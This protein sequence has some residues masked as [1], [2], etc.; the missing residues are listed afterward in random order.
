[1]NILCCGSWI[2]SWS[3]CCGMVAQC[4]L[5]LENDLFPFSYPPQVFRPG[6]IQQSSASSF[7][8][9]SKT[10][11]GEWGSSSHTSIV[12]YSART[13]PLILWLCVSKV[14]MTTRVRKDRKKSFVPRLGR[15]NKKEEDECSPMMM[16][17]HSALRSTRI[18][19]TI[20]PPSPPPPTPN[21]PHH[22]H[23]IL[24]SQIFQILHNEKSLEIPVHF[25]PMTKRKVHPPLGSTRV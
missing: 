16:T 15:M 22:H 23:P 5:P 10:L 13:T 1:M 21:P 12:E 11:N 7:L 25:C 2:P 19:L 20:T 8:P 4:T 9:A 17:F 3:I 24:P 14:L 6:K 18:R